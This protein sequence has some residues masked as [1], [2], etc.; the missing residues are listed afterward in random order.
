MQIYGLTGG[1]AS[2]KSEAAK[3]FAECGVPVIDADRVGHEVI[4][5]GGVAEAGVKEAFGDAVYTD[6][7]VDREKLGALV[8][9][10]EGAR[11]RL[12]ALVHPAIG[13]EVASRCAMLMDEGRKAVIVEAALLAEHGELEPYLT[14]LILVLSARE[15][16]LGRLTG[17]RGM[18]RE[19]AERR[20]D[21]Q[22]PPGE[23]VSL[24]R[25]VLENE[26]SL[27]DL[28]LKVDEVAEEI[29]R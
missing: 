13:A 5:P 24:A 12:N 21:A 2:G 18:P 16:R 22:T 7:Q 3:R 8:F 4:G 23:K 1:I 17:V 6:G 14:G 26:G 15:T 9:A 25:W 28:R 11:K 20:M 29:L 27:D 19:D 10:D